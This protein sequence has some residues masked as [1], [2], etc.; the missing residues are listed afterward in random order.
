M[1]LLQKVDNRQDRGYQ[2]RARS[3]DREVLIEVIEEIVGVCINPVSWLNG[4]ILPAP[5]SFGTPDADSV[6]GIYLRIDTSGQ[7]NVMHVG[8]ARDEGVGSRFIDTADHRNQRFGDDD[9]VF[10]LDRCIERT[11]VAVRIDDSDIAGC[12]S[13]WDPSS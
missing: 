13:R 2:N 6:T 11:G 1:L 3:D 9:S 10:R 7:V 4:L 8:F 5:V 12:Q